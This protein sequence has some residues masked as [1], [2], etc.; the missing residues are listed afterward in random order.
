MHFNPSIDETGALLESRS[1][2]ESSFSQNYSSIDF[3]GIITRFM[4]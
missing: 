1:I 4:S 2:S 3:N